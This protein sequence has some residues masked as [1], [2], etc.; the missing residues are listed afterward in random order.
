MTGMKKQK[1][2]IMF[3][4]GAGGS[5][6]MKVINTVMAYK[7]GF[8]KEVNYMFDKRMIVVTAPTGVAAILINGE[9][10]H[11]TAKLNYKNITSKHIDEWQKAHL[12][13]ID[14]VSFASLDILIKLNKKS[15]KL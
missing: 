4:M 15:C 14:E 1:Q 3:M 9:T 13:I 7:K 6:K 5:G 12:L 11:S 10:M 8:C 2:L